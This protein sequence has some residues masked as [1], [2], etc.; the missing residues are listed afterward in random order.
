[1]STAVI[2]GALKAVGAW[3]LSNPQIALDA[4]DKVSKIHADK[5]ASSQEETLR[6]VDEKLHQVGAATL[7]L[8]DK[9]D[10]E[11]V[12]IQNELNA[13]RK[14]IRTLKTILYIVGAVAGAAIITLILLAI[15]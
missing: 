4:V 10:T 14:E 6:I 12:G 5:K 1:M 7:E 11:V 9:I 13:L 2:L 15:F 8:E 3:V